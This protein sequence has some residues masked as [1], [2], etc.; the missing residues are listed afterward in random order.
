MVLYGFG[1]LKLK[2]INTLDQ[3]NIPPLRIIA[4]VNPPLKKAG[5]FVLHRLV[6][7]YVLMMCWDCL[8][9]NK[10]E[11]TWLPQPRFVC[12]IKPI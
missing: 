4:L 11:K 3:H 1:T 2:N 10:S 9:E 12:Y 5:F 8:F 6:Y 7:M